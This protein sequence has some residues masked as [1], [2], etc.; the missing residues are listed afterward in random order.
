VLAVLRGAGRR[1]TGPQIMQEFTRKGLG[2]SER[3]LGRWVKRLR[4]WRL[5]DHDPKADPPGFGVLVP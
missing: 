1:L 4:Q 5:I 3:N 2:H